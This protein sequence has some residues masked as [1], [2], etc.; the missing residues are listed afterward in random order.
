MEI[1]DAGAIDTIASTTTSTIIIRNI[2]LTTI[3]GSVEGDRGQRKLVEK[4]KRA[5]FQEDDEGI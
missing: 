4:M 1:A 2:I 5:T 3:D